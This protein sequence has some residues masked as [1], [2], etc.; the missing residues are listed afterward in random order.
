MATQAQL[1]RR[2][3]IYIPG[4]PF[5]GNSIKQASLGGSE[6]MGYYLA[7]GL[8][9]EGNEVVVFSGCNAPVTVDGVSYEP[10][11]E[12]NQQFPFGKLYQQKVASLPHDVTI[13]Q[14]QPGIFGWPHASAMRFWWTHDLALE[15]A[16]DQV[17]AG[18][19]NCHGILAVS[20]WHKQQVAKTYGLPESFVHVLPNGIDRD[21]FHPTDAAT[22]QRDKV[23]VYTSRP[24]RG[25]KYLL[26]PGGIME[27]LAKTVPDASL[28]ICTY[29]HMAPEMQG[30]YQQMLNWGAA[31]PNVT[32]LPSQTKQGVADLMSK[33]WLHVYPVLP[34]LDDQGHVTFEEV[35]CISAM[36]AQAGGAPCVTAPYGALPETLEGGGVY[37]AWERFTH[38]SDANEKIAEGYPK[39]DAEYQDAFATAIETLADKPD[40]WTVLHRKA[41][42]QAQAY[43]VKK[44]AGQ[45]SALVDRSQSLAAQR[46]ARLAHSLLWWSEKLAF[47]A[48]VKDGKLGWPGDWTRWVR[49]ELPRYT[50]ALTDAKAVYDESAAYNDRIQNMHHLGNDP[51]VL[52]MHRYQA[53]RP[54]V[55]QLPPGSKVLDYACGVGMGTIAWARSVRP[56]CK[57]HGVDIAALSVEKGRAYCEANKIENCTFGTADEP[58]KVPNGP[59]DLIIASEI[60]EHVVDPAKLAQGL[61]R[62]LSPTGRIV[63]TVPFGPMEAQRQDEIPWRE[64]VSHFSHHD[65]RAMFGHKPGYMWSVFGWGEVNREG[66][67]VGGTLISWQQ[68]G[69]PVNEPDYDAK[70]KYIYPRE[71]VSLCMIV[72]WNELELDKC[73]KT[74]MPFVDQAIIGIDDKGN[75]MPGSGPAWAIALEHEADQVFAL[76]A[77]PVDQ[78]FDNARNETVARATGEWVLWLDADERLCYGERMHKYLRKSW[79][80]AWAIPQHHLSVEPPGNLKTDMPCRLFRRDLGMKFIGLVHEH[81]VYSED[82]PPKHAALMNDVCIEHTGYV[83]EQVR[84]A[85]FMRNLPLIAKDREQHPKRSLGRMLWLRDLGHQAMYCQQRNDQQGMAHFATEAVKEWRSLLAL[86]D[87][88]LS[89]EG[90]PYASMAA[91]MLAGPGAIEV[92]T[93]VDT[94][95][96]GIGG[97]FGPPQ[98]VQGQFVNTDDAQAF[99]DVVQKEALKGHKSRYW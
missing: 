77:S 46:P 39:S 69:A 88:R 21:L 33:A 99:L 43:T 22:R 7:R 8:A 44:L 27:R 66:D 83:T 11:G 56:D 32:F 23:M 68:G 40:M 4:M 62:L 80:D 41:L 90:L 70:L 67:P 6:T 12:R 79:I 98:M 95:R 30:M 49:S 51:M 73:L 75:P 53:M 76:T 78:G 63:V 48:L 85:R 91:G 14:R 64:H 1:V 45:V 52:A 65:V 50:L 54:F 58:K 3:V 61:E 17:K 97:T 31:L 37:W 15:R 19:W 9:Q 59:F 20:E 10:M 87:I 35:S 13:A 38:P 94:R 29:D 82:A 57:F 16:N 5:D 93:S 60:L 89:L 74:A 2:Y 86:G 72:R 47:D 34:P 96:V 26:Q 55:E 71:H 25:L 28:L 81:P 18:L 36:E 84:R 24:E 42:K 92:R